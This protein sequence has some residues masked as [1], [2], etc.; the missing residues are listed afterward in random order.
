MTLKFDEWPWKTKGNLL[1]TMSSFV[2]HFKAIGEF[3]LGLQSGNPQLQ[4]GSKST[5]F[6]VPCE[7]EM[8]RMTL[9]N[10][11]APL[12]YYINR[13]RRNP[14]S[15]CAWLTGPEPRSGSLQLQKLQFQSVIYGDPEHSNWQFS[16]THLTIFSTVWDTCW[17]YQDNA[18]RRN[19][20][21]QKK[22]PIFCRVKPKSGEKKTIFKRI[23]YRLYIWK[24]VRKSNARWVRYNDKL[25]S[26]K[27]DRIV[28]PSRL[29]DPDRWRYDP[30]TI[31][32]NELFL[33]LPTM[34]SFHSWS[35]V[36]KVPAW[37]C[38]RRT[39]CVFL[40]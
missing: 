7:F 39:P 18:R 32:L 10:N 11:R 17:F 25:K 2:H 35:V 22:I 33:S 36:R 31:K 14:R 37:Y 16:H 9:K 24:V 34:K 28:P 40:P 6:F 19:A 30:S 26:L 23:T 13:S 29:D 8:W 3:K 1:C 5:I 38:R 21:L 4:L 12:L 27:Y 20:K 15:R